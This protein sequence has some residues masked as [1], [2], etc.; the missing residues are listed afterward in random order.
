MQAYIVWPQ[1][2]LRRGFGKARR[3]KKALHQQGIHKARIMPLEA[4]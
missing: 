4:R 1:P 2:V 3:A